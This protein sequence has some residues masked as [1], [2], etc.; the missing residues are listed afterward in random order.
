M[1]YKEKTIITSLPLIVCNKLKKDPALRDVPLI[2]MSSESSDETFEQHRKLR[3]RAED[4][5]HKPIGFQELLARIQPLVT[6]GDGDL[7]DV[8]ELQAVEV[9]TRSDARSD[10]RRD[11]RGEAVLD[12]ESL[13]D[14]EIVIEEMHSTRPPRMSDRPQPDHA[15]GNGSVSLDAALVEM[16][17]PSVP[18]APPPRVS[19][20]PDPRAA[21]LEA[22]V[23]EADERLRELERNLG[24]A[25][26]EANRAREDADRAKEETAKARAVATYARTSRNR[27]HLAAAGRTRLH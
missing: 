1:P 14:G 27:T 24:A 12:M 16:A 5:V 15:N 19:D 11:E 26:R 7:P 17:P 18:P 4:Y 3:T 6:L 20:R 9:D 25:Q 22:A 23:A 10:A 21:A 2:I 8:A 13:D